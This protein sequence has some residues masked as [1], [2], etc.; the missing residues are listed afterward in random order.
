MMYK[1]PTKMKSNRSNPLVLAALFACSVFFTSCNDEDEPAPQLPVPT[2]ENIEIGLSNNEIGIIGQDFH[3][4]VDIVAGD[5]IDYAEARIVQRSDETYSKEWSFTRVWEQYKG[6]KNTNIHSHFDIP[7][8]APEGLFDFFVTVYDENGTKAEEKRKIR[9]WKA[10]NLPVNPT[11]YVFNFS[12][13]PTDDWNFDVTTMKRGDKFYM[14]TSIDG[15]KDDGEVYLM[16]INKKHNYKP[17]SLTGLDFSKVIV[18]E[19]REHTAIPNST[20]WRVIE[21]PKII[22][23]E[24]TKDKLG[25]D[26]VWEDGDYW[27]AMIYNNTTHNMGTFEYK[28]VKL[29]P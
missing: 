8:D 14:V 16:L 19:T 26:I 27:A 11:V 17:E 6:A 25:N 15:V 23:G 21:S 7:E 12:A 1:T 10:E 9:I 18:Y 29:I 24:T 4:N 28:E 3:F 5:R 2:M 13:S 20:L 22:I